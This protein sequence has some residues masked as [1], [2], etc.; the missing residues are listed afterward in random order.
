VDNADRSSRLPRATPN[1]PPVIFSRAGATAASLTPAIGA[2]T[3]F[4]AM[5]IY[6]ITYDL[7]E[8]TYENELLAHIKVG[9]W[10]KLTP[11]SY[12]VIRDDT[13]DAIISEIRRITNDTV[14]VYALSI[15]SPWNGLGLTEVNDWLAA[16]LR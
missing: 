11:S 10:A 12:A 9:P 4:S 14:T 1:T 3:V 16:N 5:A 8:K 2:S 15:C 13:P 6:L 7:R